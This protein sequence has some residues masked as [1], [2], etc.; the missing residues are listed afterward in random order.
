MKLTTEINITEGARN[1]LSSVS[2]GAAGLRLSIRGGKGCG[3]N[4]YDL[5]PLASD[6]IDGSDDFI[7]LNDTCN[8]YIPAMDMLKLFGAKID[9]IEDDLGNRRIDISNPNESGKCG[10]GKS[11]TF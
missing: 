6:A 11:V 10:C 1:Y 7:Q 3:G 4:E 8:L 5:K 9:F 2:N